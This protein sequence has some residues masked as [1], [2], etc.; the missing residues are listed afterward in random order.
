MMSG[1]GPKKELQNHNIKLVHDLPV[2]HNLQD[3]P[4]IPGFVR[5]GKPDGQM[6]VNAFEVLNPLTMLEFYSSGTGPLA[7]NN[8]G[9]IG[10]MHTPHNK[11]QKRPGKF[12][13]FHYQLLE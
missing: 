4:M 3:H 12:A 5:I 6:T 8:M 13:D 9:V 10:V 1:I 2:G 7:T 11:N